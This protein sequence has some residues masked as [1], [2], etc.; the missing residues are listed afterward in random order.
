MCYSARGPNGFSE[1]EGPMGRANR[2]RKLNKKK[3]PATKPPKER[4]R[5]GISEGPQITPAWKRRRSH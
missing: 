1:T 3:G 2:N 4:K 5:R